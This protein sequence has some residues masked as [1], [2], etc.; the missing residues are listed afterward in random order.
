[1][2]VDFTLAKADTFYKVG[3]QQEAFNSLDVIEPLVEKI[4]HETKD[5]NT[6]ENFDLIEREADLQN[7]KALL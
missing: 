3:K 1:M 5:V 2:L 4:K 7:V 6:K